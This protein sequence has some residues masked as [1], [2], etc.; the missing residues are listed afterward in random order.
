[1]GN[2]LSNSATDAGP[3]DANDDSGPRYPVSPYNGVQPSGT[4]SAQDETEPTMRRPTTPYMPNVLTI[5]TNVS[6]PTLTSGPSAYPTTLESTLDVVTEQPTSQMNEPDVTP[7]LFSPTTPEPTVTPETPTIYE[8]PMDRTPAPPSAQ[9]SSDRLPSE[10]KSRK[11]SPS[12]R[13]RQH[14]QNRLDDRT[15]MNSKPSIFDESE[16]EEP[17]NIDSI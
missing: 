12:H 11:D 8:T 3:S 10:R 6:S 14:A 15:K 7:N 13:R 4:E 9:L 16:Y 17:T 2:L 5:P 1:M